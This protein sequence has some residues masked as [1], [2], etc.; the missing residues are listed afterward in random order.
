[1]V[2]ILDYTTKTPLQMIGALSGVC[3]GVKDSTPEKDKKR[4]IN[5][6]MSGHGRTEEFP[7]IYMIISDH[8]IK[9]MREF[10]THIGGMPTRLQESTRYVDYSKQE[11]DVH[12]PGKIMGNN[13]AKEKFFDAV[14]SCYTTYCRLI[15][16]GVPPEDASYIL[17]LG[18]DTKVVVK[19]NLRTLVEMSHQRMCSRAHWEFQKIMGEIKW[20]L[21]LYS[22][23]W[24]EIA[25]N[26]LEPKCEYLGFCPEK[27]SCGRKEQRKD[28]TWTHFDPEKGFHE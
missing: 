9:V 24:K 28:K 12:V 4:A 16:L 22:D 7:D 5:C 23:E 17:P 14:Q 27:N 18:I 25:T 10:Y 15:E 11:P 3:Y 19:M 26:L 21:L 1:M 13:E 6:I 2:E 20:A 8:S